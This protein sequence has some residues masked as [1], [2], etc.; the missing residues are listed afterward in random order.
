MFGTKENLFFNICQQLYNEYNPLKQTKELYSYLVNTFSRYSLDTS[1]IN[2]ENTRKL[3]ND[4]ILKYYPNEITIKSSFV[5]KVLLKNNSHTSI[6]FELNSGTSRVDL[7]KING[8]SIAFEI[9]TDLDNF[10]RLNKQLN[11]YFRIFEKVFVICSSKNINNI[12]KL[13][14]DE[15]GIYSYHITKTGKYIFNKE[16]DAL[17]SSQINSKNQL[18]LFTKTE[19]NNFFNIKSLL[20]KNDMINHILANYDKEYINKAFK[21]NFKTKYKKNWEFLS[22]NYSNILEIDY[23]WFFKNNIDPKLIYKKSA[24]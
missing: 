4:N 15:C 9:K 18:L 17:F 23:Q 20:N 3:F 13:I 14:P 10:N 11:D 12:I 24:I 22:N 21:E 1:Y 8:H 6:I 19:L 2:I 5:N 16:R 7:C